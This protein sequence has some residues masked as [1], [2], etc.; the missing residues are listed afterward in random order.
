MPL[1]FAHAEFYIQ[2]GFPPL[3]LYLN[4]RIKKSPPSESLSKIPQVEPEFLECNIHISVKAHVT[5]Y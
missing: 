4:Y 2:N 3:F 5:L 1:F